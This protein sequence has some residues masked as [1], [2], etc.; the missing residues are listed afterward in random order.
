MSLVITVENSVNS[1][2]HVKNSKAFAELEDDIDDISDYF[3]LFFSG[4]P[5]VSYIFTKLSPTCF[6][7]SAFS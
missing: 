1:T 7:N 6:V 4:Y 2:N 3:I 5:N